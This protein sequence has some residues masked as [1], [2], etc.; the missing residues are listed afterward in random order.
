MRPA[1]AVVL[2]AGLAVLLPDR[3]EAH[4]FGQRYDLPLPLGF[5]LGAAG[6]AV[7]L[8]FVGSFLFMRP[9]PRRRLAI[10][11]AVP[12]ALA[13]AVRGAGRGVAIA[14][15]GLVLATALAGPE[16]PTENLATVA[17]WVLWWVGL[18][19]FTALVADLWTPLNP[20]ATLVEGALRLGGAGRG[21]LRLPRRAEWLSVAGLLALAWLELVSDWSEAPRA[22]GVI[23]GLYTLGLLAGA[24]AFGRRRWFVTADP[25]TR[26]F[27]LLGRVAPVSLR[28]RAV[29]LRLPASG[30]VGRPL[31]PAG[32]VFVV[33]LIGIVLFD[34]LSE[35]PVWAG[36]LD[37]IT[38]SQTL[39][40]WLLEARGQ[41]VDLL[42]LIR[43]LGLAATVVLANLAYLALAA[44][45]WRAAGQG[46]LAR[47]FTGF[48]TSLLPIA[49][50]YHLAHYVSYLALAGQLVLPIASDPFGLGW[51]LFGTAGRS[52]D[53]GVI[54]AE[55]VWW[56]AA[57]ALVTG[58][59]LSVLVA[60]AEALR[61]YAPAGRAV[62][63]QVPMMVFMV[64]L[65]CLSLWILSQPIV[66]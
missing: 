19:L 64:G 6:L 50:A 18:A 54:T 21:R 15:L 59:A 1:A 25:V 17:V 45:V 13:E 46:T 60:H 23:V 48:A 61:L 58:H 39:R 2:A 26:L 3:G 32:A 20:F 65:T 11:L 52:V 38:R 49:V 42:K 12:R 35:T 62:R 5:Y 57:V 27:R 7:A 22:V 16:A 56:I 4:A 29:R 55:D 41:G 30:L 47:A 43:T 31:T 44:A 36:V 10:D 24:A 51:D 34:G 9:G 8:S 33:T 63:S 40:P 53:L 37:W 28:R 14:L 66:E